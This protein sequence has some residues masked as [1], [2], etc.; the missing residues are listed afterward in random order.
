MTCA[1]FEESDRPGQP[2][3][4]IRVFAVRS[5]GSYGLKVPSCGQR[6]LWS[7]WADAQADLRLCRAHIWFCLFCRAP[8]QMT[9]SL[10]KQMS[11]QGVKDLTWRF[12]E[13]TSFGLIFNSK[14][15]HWSSEATDDSVQQSESFTGNQNKQQT[16]KQSVFRLES[17]TN[18]LV[19]R[20]FYINAKFMNEKW[21]TIST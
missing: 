8:T 11:S 17:E 1:P 3:C 20:Q 13:M 4:L 10:Q 5:I 16:N 6:R 14:S 9:S 15:A 2:T 19:I 18:M 12:F 21:L 7:D